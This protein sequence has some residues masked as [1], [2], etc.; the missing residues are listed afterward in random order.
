MY[1]NEPTPSPRTTGL[2]AWSKVGRASAAIG[3]CHVLSM[4]LA[5][6]L[7]CDLFPAAPDVLQPP[8]RLAHPGEPTLAAPAADAMHWQA[9]PERVAAISRDVAHLVRRGAQRWPLWLAPLL[10]YAAFGRFVRVFWLLAM[11]AV[12]TRSAALLSLGRQPMQWGVL[13]L[14]LPIQGVILWLLANSLGSPWLR[15]QLGAHA[16]PAYLAMLLSAGCISLGLTTY[17]DFCLTYAGWGM[18]LSRA[19]RQSRRAPIWRAM[20][21]KVQLGAGSAA[22]TALGLYGAVVLREAPL[23]LLGVQQVLS[24]GALLLAAQWVAV[25]AVLCEPGAADSKLSPQTR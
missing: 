6:A 13:G 2:A 24:M 7:A 16:L 4:T 1:A 25:C 22:T 9:S 17:V 11:S 8:A 19:L 23:W 14:W 15:D 5:W 21:W 18:P 10:I 20:A 3:L 12:P